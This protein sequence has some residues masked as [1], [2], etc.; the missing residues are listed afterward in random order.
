[1]NAP[2]ARDF[3]YSVQLLHLFIKHHCHVQS[4][5]FSCI[6]WPQDIRL[7]FQLSFPQ[8]SSAFPLFFFAFP[9]S[10]LRWRLVVRFLYHGRPLDWSSFVC[11]LRIRFR[12]VNEM[13]LNEMWNLLYLGDF[14]AT[15]AALRKRMW[16]WIGI[17]WIFGGKG[18]TIGNETKHSNAKQSP[19]RL[20]FRM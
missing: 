8:F 10:L 7:L 18:I 6:A 13:E 5:I 3:I 19:F 4:Y 16:M 17:G 15:S 1:M 9:H 20:L 14:H 11:L 12:I 2:E